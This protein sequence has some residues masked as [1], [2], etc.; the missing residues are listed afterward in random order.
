[1]IFE[2]LRVCTVMNWK[3][4]CLALKTQTDIDNTM[5]E[6]RQKWLLPMFS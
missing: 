6:T 3:L 5:V 2:C 4:Y 1:M